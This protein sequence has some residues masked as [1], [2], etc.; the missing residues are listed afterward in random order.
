[1]AVHEYVKYIQYTLAAAGFYNKAIDGEYG[2]S[3]ASAVR[4]FQVENNERYIDGKV[5]SETK[6]YLAK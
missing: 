5:D 6:W 1:M 3:T 4:S 2:S